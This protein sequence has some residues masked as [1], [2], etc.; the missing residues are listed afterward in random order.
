MTKT[1]PI[2]TAR[3][4]LV[5]NVA[6][7]VAALSPLEGA[8]FSIAAV[9]ADLRAATYERNEEIEG[10]LDL[11]V[12]GEHGL[13]LGEPG[14]GKSFLI[15]CVTNS[16]EE[17]GA[18]ASLF[19]YQLTRFTEPAELFGPVDLAIMATG[20]I[21]FVTEGKLPS[22]RL[23][24]LDETFKAS[25]ALLNA[26]LAATNERLFFGN[27]KPE[28]IPLRCLFGASNETPEKGEET[29]ALE[30]RFALRF[31]VKPIED[32][33][34]RRAYLFG[35]KLPRPTARVTIAELD[36]LRAH[37]A[38]LSISPEAQEALLAIFTEAAAKGLL[39]SDR[40]QKKI[41]E[42]LKARAARVGAA[43]VTRRHLDVLRYSLWRRL[44]E[45]PTV[46]AIVEK[47]GVAEIAEIRRIS[48][49]LDEQRSALAGAAKKAKRRS[50][51]LGEVTKIERCLD[52]IEASI[53]GLSGDSAAEKADLEAKLA[54][55]RAIAERSLR[56][57]GAGA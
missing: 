14:T 34:N 1:M 26:L 28:K 15:D 57:G 37:A 4:A 40:K 48:A 42:I 17:D 16:V 22:V 52:E 29:G 31:S 49:A 2:E 25:S 44:E 35:A 11:L 45:I 18:E 54:D 13:L 10:L 8:C 21:R 9:G 41:I 12:A 38:T 23:A 27:G 5:D 36:L 24:Y 30:D 46:D 43:A 39:V 53:A 47:H 20:K 56:G 51:L 33:A 19:K 6:A 7:P 3:L 55:A 32:D 50:D